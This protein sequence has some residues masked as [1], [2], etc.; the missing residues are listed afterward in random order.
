[1]IKKERQKREIFFIVCYGS[2]N[3]KLTFFC[4]VT[5]NKQEQELQNE[6]HLSHPHDDP[7]PYIRDH[8]IGY[9]NPRPVPVLRP[10]HRKPSEQAPKCCI[11]ADA[12]W[13]MAQHHGQSFWWRKV[14]LTILSLS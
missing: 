14:E 6:Q 5:N 4:Q 13:G 11:G 3:L 8:G 12:G 1:M 7:P 2:Q 10:R 9:P